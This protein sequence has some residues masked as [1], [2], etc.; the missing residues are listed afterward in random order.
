MEFASA[1]STA[2]ARLAIGSGEP[3]PQPPKST[4]SEDTNNPAIATT[5]DPVPPA[6]AGSGGGTPG[7]DPETVR[8][9]Q[10]INRAANVALNRLAAAA[11]AKRG[12][13]RPRKYP[14]PVA[15][16]LVAPGASANVAAEGGG[17]EVHG[18]P[19]DDRSAEI[20]VE[21]IVGLVESI[22]GTIQ[23]IAVFHLTK[24]AEAAKEAEAAAK[25]TG[26]TRDLIVTGGKE[27]AKK[28]G[29]RFQ[30]LP[31]TAFFGGLAIYGTG[32][33]LN[34]RAVREEWEKKK[35]E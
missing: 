11:P 17:A 18:E 20:L 30:Y 28:H 5:P 19:L 27:C 1:I 2:A 3:K 6:A 16:A 33:V 15:P 8:R 7:G 24:S 23:R 21:G 34:F 9:E 4:M 13:G 31:E 12:P 32:Q 35:P 25:I 10:E 29:A 14:A 26:S 22:A